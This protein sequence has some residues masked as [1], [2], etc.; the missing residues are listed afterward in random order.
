MTSDTR[1]D[2]LRCALTEGDTKTA[3]SLLD[4]VRSQKYPKALLR[5]LL[6]SCSPG[7]D[8]SFLD[9]D[10]VPPS[11]LIAPCLPEALETAPLDE[12]R[13]LLTHGCTP[14]EFVTKHL[15]EVLRGECPLYEDLPALSIY[16]YLELAQRS[17][18]R[19]G[20]LKRLTALEC[21]AL[22]ATSGIQN[23]VSALSRWRRSQHD[24][25][26]EE[27][28]ILIHRSDYDKESDNQGI[29]FTNH[30]IRS[31]RDTGESYALIQ[32][33]TDQLLKGGATYLLWNRSGQPPESWI[34]IARGI[35]QHKTKLLH[36]IGETR[37]GLEEINPI[38]F[39]KERSLLSIDAAWLTRRS[40]EQVLSFFQHWLGESNPRW[41]S[42][43]KIE[44]KKQPEPLIRPNICEG[45]LVIAASQ[46]QVREVGLKALKNRATRR[47]LEGGF[48]RGFV[49]TLG[50][51]SDQSISQQL[52]DLQ[53]ANSEA[54]Q[55][56]AFMGADDLVTPNAWEQLFRRMSIKSDVIL[57]SDEE[58]QWSSNPIKIGQRQFAG[59]STPF[60]A[61]SR[62]HL[63]GL[64]AVQA[65]LFLQLEFKE[66]YLS[67]HAFLKD[68]GLQWMGSR[69]EVET[70]PQAL[71]HR[72]LRSNPTV[73][74]IST[75][76]QHEAFNKEQLQELDEITLRGAAPWMQP[77]GRIERGN[78]AGSFEINRTKL[79]EDK[80]S[81]IIP[82]RDQAA[83]TQECVL[84]LLQHEK[85][86]S[87]EIILIDN[88]STE[89]AAKE[90]TDTLKYQAQSQ[91]I[92]LIGLHDDSPFN[93]SALNNKARQEC[94]GN[95]LL[96][97]NNDIRFESPN[98]LEHLLNPFA[99]KCTGA[100][101]SRLIYEDGTIQHHGLVS[102]AYQSHDILSAGKG[103]RPGNETNPFASL[104]L[105]EEWSA[106]TAAC[107]VVRAKD[108]D[109]IGGFNEEFTVAYNDV[110]LCWRLSKENLATIVTP[111]PTIIHAE[112][113]TRGEDIA[114]EKRNR[115]ARESGRLRKI[116]PIYFQNGDP[117]YHQFL[118]PASHQFEPLELPTKPVGDSRSRLLYSWTKANFK[119]SEKPFLIYVHY[120]RDGNVR[121]DIYEQLKSYKTHSDVAFVSASPKLLDQTE[122]M[123]KLH[124]ICDVIIVRHNE[125]YDFGSWQAGIFYCQRYLQNVSKLILTNDSC[126]GPLHSFDKLFERLST[127]T[128]DVIGLTDSTAVRQHLQSYFIAYG[129]RILTSSLFWKFW[130]K[131]KIWPSKVDLVRAY[132]VGWSEILMK[133]GFK[134]EALYL[135][136]E[137]GNVTHTHWRELLVDNEFPF[138]KTELLRVNPILQDIS[139]WEQIAQKANPKV[140]QMIADHLQ[141]LRKKQTA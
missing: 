126:Y 4:Q 128:A 39:I 33:A 26:L 120:D 102:A 117:L 94:S 115:L 12:R 81:I 41:S 93:F 49:L 61:I 90:L 127:S 92:K 135:E 2:R 91:G 114:G 87:F 22:E 106:A 125:G 131:I 32:N 111:Q 137:H 100:V 129:S 139:G 119:A 50:C 138:I 116:Y 23:E 9:L 40:P 79:S 132:E 85:S 101:S 109:R 62:G 130:E 98:P 72:N 68:I 27:P 74:N 95:F 77:E 31:V 122:M 64:V 52:R 14:A 66:K 70:L 67:L 45:T 48:T 140:S 10:L 44:L 73:L 36:Q 69:K 141:A 53:K 113:K 13:L 15:N 121:S 56:V 58:V 55:I 59:K 71:L 76:E 104:M 82:F 21:L 8:E 123:D 29:N 96:F 54:T 134:L 136:G 37:H 47:A 51:C 16:T 19:C 133:A 99:L 46:E 124:D 42:E 83:L 108:F 88:G 57:C 112:S 60:R 110:D 103:L 107:L 35:K 18:A 11:L 30:R 38:R 65:D 17:P 7:L 80:V 34:S 3:L 97:L 63:P 20:W 24:A 86:T 43:A 84:S 118:H 89:K 105:Q 1:M 28:C 25:L 75:S 5:P 6:A 78:R